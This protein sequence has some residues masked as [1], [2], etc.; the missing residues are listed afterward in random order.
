M[1]DPAVRPGPATGG[2]TVPEKNLHDARLKLAGSGLTDSGKLGFELMERG[3]DRAVPP[4][5]R[6]S[7]W[8]P[9]T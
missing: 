5:P 9:V 6:R 7:S 3:P 2:I 1:A 4:P 8:R